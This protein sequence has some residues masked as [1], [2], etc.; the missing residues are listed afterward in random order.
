MS[1]SLVG[2]EMCI[3]DR[4]KELQ[5]V[6]LHCPEARSQSIIPLRALRRVLLGL[7][8]GDQGA[9]EVCYRGAVA[10]A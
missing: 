2:S 1:A 8:R 3:R 7:C 5:W 9:V 6:T 4:L 10:V